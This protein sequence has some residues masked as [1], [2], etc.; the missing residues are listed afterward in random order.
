MQ[1]DLL[2]VILTETRK[3]GKKRWEYNPWT[4][5]YCNMTCIGA[6]DEGDEAIAFLQDYAD[7]QVRASESFGWKCYIDRASDGWIN[8]YTCLKGDTGYTT[9]FYRRCANPNI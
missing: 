9:M 1:H 2:I 7:R 4:R 5:D 6:F 3:N 8:S